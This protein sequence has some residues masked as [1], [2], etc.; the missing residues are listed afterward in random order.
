[1]SLL[2]PD[3]AQY[4][5]DKLIEIDASVNS[6]SRDRFKDL[7]SVLDTLFKELT[8]SE[9]QYFQNVFSRSNFIF[10]KYDVSPVVKDEV[11][12]LRVKANHIHHNIG[13]DVSDD[14]ILTGLKAL[15]LAVNHFSGTEEPAVLS[16]KY[17][18][19]PELTFKQSRKFNHTHVSELQLTVVEIIPHASYAYQTTLK[20][21][22]GDLG[23]VIINLYNPREEKDFWLGGFAEVG[24][25]LW[26]Y[27][28]I[29]FYNVQLKEGTENVYS[30]TPRSIMVLEPD[31]LIEASKLAE[32][33]D[34]QG[35][36]PNIYLLGKFKQSE[37]NYKMMLG[38]VANSILDRVALDP[39]AAHLDVRHEP[40][41]EQ[42]FG[43]LCVAQQAAN[44]NPNILHEMHNDATPH[45]AV[46]EAVMQ[47]YRDYKLFIEPTYFSTKYGLHGRLDMMAQDPA[48]DKR[49]NI[50][51]LKSGSAPGP[52]YNGG[53]WG[54]NK[55]QVQCYNMLLES[56][57]PGRTGDS[58]IL[59]SNPGNQNI[60]LRNHADSVQIRQELMTVRNMIVINDFMLAEAPEKVLGRFNPDKFG[61][62]PQ[63][64]EETLQALYSSMRNAAP[65]ELKYFR[66]FIG[67]V[68]REQRT[69]KIG[70]DEV[71]GAPGF[72][73]LWKSTRNEKR[74]TFSILDYL[75]FVSLSGN[76]E[77][78]LSRNVLSD[79]MSNL[80]EGDITILYPIIEDDEQAAIKSQI[81]K[82]N[83]K[84]ITDREVIVSLRSKTLDTAYFKQYPFWA[85]ERDLMEKGFDDMF[86]SLASF[87][88]AP[89]PK[90]DL[91]FGLKEPEFD[92]IGYDVTGDLTEEQRGLMK[93]AL[94]AKDYFL[95]QGPPGTGK[96]SRMLRNMVQ[97]I[98]DNTDENIMV[99][100]F[101]NSAVEEI[102]RH[103]DKAGLPHLR[104]SRSGAATNCFNKLAEVKTVGELN[105]LVQETRIFICTQASFGGFGHITKL[106]K[107]STVIVDEASQ[108]LEP[109][110][111]GILPLFERFILI[112][113]EKQL[114]AVVTQAD[115]YTKV[116]SPELEQLRIKSLKN[117]LFSRLLA[118]CQA[119]GWSNAYGMLTKQGRM[120]KEI[121]DYVS[122][123]Y[124]NN[125]LQPI[126][127]EQFEVQDTFKIDSENK[128]ERA[129]ATSRLIFVPA[130]REAVSKV[131]V[132]EANFVAGFIKAVHKVY[133]GEFD[134]DSIGVVTPY[135]SQIA[136][137]KRSG[138]VEDSI[139]QLVDVDTVERFQ[140][141]E[142][143]VIIISLAVNHH[144]QMQFL[145]SITDDGIVDRKLN[146]ALTRA[147]KHVVVIGCESVLRTS[148]SYRK[149]LDYISAKG[150]FVDLSKK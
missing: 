2:T 20:G 65:Y 124:Y 131:S 46:I 145:E 37:S 10:D 44:F 32:C 147:K 34:R 57:F 112:G 113:D 101:T 87:L 129:L 5:Y 89:K 51:E 127:D 22:A 63:F 78:R 110:L 141:S 71:E 82:C 39:G 72:S 16:A 12:G 138:N 135:R 52:N 54:N 24:K 130:P 68:A 59:Y 77:V 103:L 3:S 17:K 133:R 90:R 47:N 109:H 96:T 15:A 31:Y 92:T 121:C 69:A 4:Y 64:D 18:D 21:D 119:N 58:A 49:K 94:S 83:I 61:P 116:Q 35:L 66:E 33:F 28:H 55:A 9:S 45:V 56:T 81:L 8:H 70:S 118:T 111:V 25:R 74:K 85:L 93:Q 11:H 6:K 79:R 105:D 27:A 42:A 136:T 67:F 23:E 50:V 86:K 100:A 43:M 128:Y 108:L 29:A 140:G 107:F 76:S 126:H 62:R 120:H 19:R 149:L 91:L 123:E 102:C 144:K 80:R 84:R 1:M 95:L 75:E 104:L 14:D 97:N 60:P 30:T 48:D 125:Q 41:S 139:M 99:M 150:G 88:Q 73:A 148:D 137:I 114:P 146:V 106:K 38:N 142:R 115:K 40:M 122:N 143:D 134:K 13:A 36:N 117:S 26:K 53:L 132:G 98:H 7:R